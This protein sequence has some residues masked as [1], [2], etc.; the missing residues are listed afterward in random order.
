MGR[1]DRMLSKLRDFLRKGETVFYAPAY[2]KA[3]VG[4]REIRFWD[5][6]PVRVR[7]RGDRDG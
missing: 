3:K 1:R 6:I 2:V 7:L 4:G 5:V